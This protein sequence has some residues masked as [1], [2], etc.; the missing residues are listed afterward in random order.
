MPV[1]FRFEVR[2]HSGRLA[3]RKSRLDFNRRAPNRT[4]HASQS[5]RSWLSNDRRG[6]RKSTGAIG[7]AGADPTLVHV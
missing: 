5:Q 4:G 6:I 2:H 3:S 7:L 1:F